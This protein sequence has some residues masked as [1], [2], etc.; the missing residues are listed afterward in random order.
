MCLLV[1]NLEL[2]C[3][4]LHLYKTNHICCL[5]KRGHVFTSNKFELMCLLVLALNFIQI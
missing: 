2:K 1:I 4:L 3:L 5:L